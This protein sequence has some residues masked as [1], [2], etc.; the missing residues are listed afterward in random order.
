MELL[1]VILIVGILTAIAIPAF[2]DQED[3]ANDAAAMSALATA[4]KAIEI[5]RIDHGTVCTAHLSDLVAIEPT[6]GNA[7]TLSL[8]ACS[9]GDPE[10]YTLT[11][12]SDSQRHTTF[13]LVLT[14]AGELERT[15]SPAGKGACQ[16][17]GSW[18]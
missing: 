7:S 10:G 18:G 15:C 6:L 11:L 17:D 1:V 9:S 2:L 13:D 12:A 4:Y 3:K 8:D 16:N 5:Y 14:G